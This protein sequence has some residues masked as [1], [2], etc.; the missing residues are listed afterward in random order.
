MVMQRIKDTAQNEFT[1]ATRRATFILHRDVVLRTPFAFGTLRNSILPETLSTT[2]G[3][4]G[5]V[6]TAVRY[7]LPVET[8]SRPHWPP[9]EPLI[10]WVKRKL[11][12]KGSMMQLEAKDTA[13]I[14]RRDV[15][16]GLAK[17]K[18]VGRHNLKSGVILEKMIRSRAFL[19]AR[20]ISKRGTKAHR[21][22]ETAFNAR[23]ADVQRIFE[24]AVDRFVN[25]VSKL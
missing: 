7:A 10:L 9:I 13:R 21:M 20:A 1:T 25:K 15:Q 19:I 12:G 22:F 4:I 24:E 2:Q 16:I 11:A 17:G 18:F 14:Q 5:H 8:G 6:T 23:A 3:I